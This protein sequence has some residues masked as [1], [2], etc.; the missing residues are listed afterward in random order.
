[1]IAALK[2]VAAEFGIT[3]SDAAL[4]YAATSIGIGLGGILM[5]WL[6]D[7][8]GMM[9]PSMIGTACLSLGLL[10]A[11]TTHDPWLFVAAHG[12]L[13]GLLG[14]AAF[15]APLVADITRWFSTNRGVAVAIVISGNYI[16]GT[17]WPPIVQYGID[18]AGWRITYQW[19]AGICLIAMFPLTMIL[20]R[21]AALD[22]VEGDV[23][24]ATRGRTL[25]LSPWVAQCFLCAA[26]VGCCVAMAVPQAHIV[27]HADDLGYAAARGA[28]MAALMFGF[29]IV[30]R[31]GFGWLSDRIGGLRTVIVG[32]AMQALAIAS[33]IPISGLTTLYWASALFGL[34][35]GGI[36]P[37]Y[38]IIIRRHFP[39]TDVG[40]RVGLVMLFTMLGMAFGAWI[41]GVLHD[42]TGSYDAAFVNA[43]L[44]NL[45]NLAIALTLLAKMRFAKLA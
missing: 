15:M 27:A 9:W 44:F 30:S 17:L 5:G 11:G 23:N 43:V 1:M 32:S 10:V 34:S 22:A 33:F 36:V 21:R 20:W 37:A 31:L 16:A 40:W 3:R 7:R 45:M 13:I 25:G 18:I 26:G 42:L 8:V 2:P 41:A 4:A 28:E 39:A 12:L 29:G 6:S 24:S 35:Q 38:A 19:L 14:S